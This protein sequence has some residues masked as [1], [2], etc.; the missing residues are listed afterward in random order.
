MPA[1]RAENL[2]HARPQIVI[3]RRTA[4]GIFN[5]RLGASNH[6]HPADYQLEGIGKIH[7][8]PSEFKSL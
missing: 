5:R 3:Y 4:H 2:G 8:G 6:A 7:S 1:Q